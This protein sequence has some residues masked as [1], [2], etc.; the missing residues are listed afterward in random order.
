MPIDKRQPWGEPGTLPA[1]GMLIRS[2]AEGRRVVTEALR[3]GRQPPALGLIGG[4]LARTMGAP[5][6]GSGLREATMVFPV[7][8]GVAVI[9]GERHWFLA[10]AIARRSWWRGRIVAAMNAEWV[11]RWDVAPRAHPDDGLLD[12]L[13]G[14]LSL[15]DRL[16]ARS[17]LRTGAHLPHPRIS[18]RRSSGADYE[19]DRPLDVYLDGE[20]VA[21]SSRLTVE[22]L[23]DALVCVV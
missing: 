1:G 12:L 11:G 5:A 9:G 17:R 13:D 20:R 6:G 23:P 3:A 4:D 21:R 22:V 16:K 2:N 10:H 14:D 18:V 15:D 8:L 19:F 7:D